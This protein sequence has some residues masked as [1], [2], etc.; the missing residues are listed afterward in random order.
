M[1]G[2]N[3]RRDQGDDHGPPH[4]SANLP[5]VCLGR[6]LWVTHALSRCTPIRYG[7]IGSSSATHEATLFGHSIYPICTGT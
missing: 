5:H 1:S 3:S 7:R 6:T 4:P 2:N